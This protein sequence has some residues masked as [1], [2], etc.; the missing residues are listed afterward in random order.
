MIKFHLFAFK[1]QQFFLS[2]ANFKKFDT[3]SSGC[4]NSY[5]LRSALKSAGKF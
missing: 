4:L 5:E 1:T 3:D 2:Q